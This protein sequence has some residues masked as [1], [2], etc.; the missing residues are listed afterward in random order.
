MANF[1]VHLSNTEM[2]KGEYSQA[3][4]STVAGA[5]FPESSIGI[6]IIAVTN[7]GDY[8]WISGMASSLADLDADEATGTGAVGNNLTPEEAFG[9]DSKID[10]GVGDAGI[11]Q[12]ITQF[13]GGAL[14]DDTATG[15]SEC[16]TTGEYNLAY[17]ARACSIRIKASF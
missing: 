1:W 4:A 11:I 5:A 17:E 6:G 8:N 12:V 13:T 9:I 16:M 7:N 3:S 15:A 10:D 2:V 14:T